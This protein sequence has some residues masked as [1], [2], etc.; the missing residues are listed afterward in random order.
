MK[1]L[2]SLILS[3]A[4]V[5][6]LSMPAFATKKF[7]T[8]VFDGRDDF[9]ISGDEM[10]G[11][12]AVIPVTE[13]FKG[14]IVLFDRA[15]VI[16]SPFIYLN[17]DNDLYLFHFDCYGLDFS[18]LNSI[19]I[20]IGDDRYTFSDC[21]ISTSVTTDN[22]IHES[23]GFFLKRETVGFMKDFVE[24]RDEEIKVRLVGAYQNQDF[25]LTDDMKNQLLTLY[26]LYTSGGGTRDQNLLS[27]TN[28]DRV[29]VEKN[30][31]VVDGHIKEEVIDT[32]F[33]AL[34]AVV[35]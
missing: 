18:G 5:F 11:T 31:K 1:K 27:I 19:I 29:V 4:L 22:F 6:S 9:T 20:K 21:Y 10:A 30:G 13:H 25:S 23:I 12:L 16:T 14:S 26:D 7:D 24:H 3:A 33:Q 8:S 17:D 32:L 15:F 35:S 28:T 2:I 34:D